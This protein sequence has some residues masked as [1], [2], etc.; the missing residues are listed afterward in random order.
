MYEYFVANSHSFANCTLLNYRKHML[1]QK[2]WATADCGD[3]KV[4]YRISEFEL[5]SFCLP[6]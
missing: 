4:T 1:Q 2:G 5:I 3:K 6:V